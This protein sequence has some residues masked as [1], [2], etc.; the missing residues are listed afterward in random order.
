[1]LKDRGTYEIMDPAEVGWD[2]VGIALTKHSGR[3][4]PAY[5]LDRIGHRFVGNSLDDMFV[6]FKAFADTVKEVGDHDLYRLIAEA[7]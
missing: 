1:M 6:R 7:A 2:E 4:A 5:R 3:A